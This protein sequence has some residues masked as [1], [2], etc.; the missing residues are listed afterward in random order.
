MPPPFDQTFAALPYDG[1]IAFVDAMVGRWLDHLARL[2]MAAVYERLGR[3]AEALAEHTTLTDAQD[4]KPNSRQ[5]ANTRV[6]ALA[7]PH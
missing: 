2:E 4:T 6:D 1:E 7:T 5:A 3:R